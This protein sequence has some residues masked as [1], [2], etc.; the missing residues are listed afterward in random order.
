MKRSKRST[1]RT[2]VSV[3]PVAEAIVLDHSL[4]YSEAD[5]EADVSPVSTHYRES[6]RRFFATV[7]AALLLIGTEEGARAA[8]EH[9]AAASSGHYASSRNSHRLHEKPKCKRC[10]TIVSKREVDYGGNG[11]G[12]A[13]AGADG[14]IRLAALY[15]FT[16]RLPDG[17]LRVITSTNAEAWREGERVSVIEGAKL[18][19]KTHG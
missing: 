7:F 14:H 4:P 18:A 11:L 12:D 8:F 2:R 9:P 16:V 5:G 1:L 10:G 17:S 15:Q 3:L 13:A 6:W 19:N